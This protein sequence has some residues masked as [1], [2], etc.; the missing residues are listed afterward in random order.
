MSKNRMEARI[1]FLERALR[2][3]TRRKRKRWG[4]PPPWYGYL[5]PATGLAALIVSILSANLSWSAYQLNRN[6]RD[7]STTPKLTISEVGLTHP[8]GKAHDIPVLSYQIKNYGALVTND[9][10]T[11]L[12]YRYAV[13]PIDMGKPIPPVGTNR[14]SMGLGPKLVPGDH[15]DRMFALFTH[16]IQTSTQPSELTFANSQDPPSYQKLRDGMAVL[17]VEISTQANDAA[18]HRIVL[19]DAFEYQWITDK[20]ERDPPCLAADIIGSFRSPGAPKVGR[21]DPST[22]TLIPEK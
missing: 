13:G 20:F 10:H 1:T 2:E 22:M 14:E 21:V 8:R 9:I 11:Y 3:P 17:R 12:Q 19:C 18:G 6:N 15:L 7:D 4:T 5:A 16:L